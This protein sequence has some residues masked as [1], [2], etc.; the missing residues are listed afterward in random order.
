MNSLPPR[1]AFFSPNNTVPNYGI[2][3]RMEIASQFSGAGGLDLGFTRAGHRVVWEES[4]MLHG[5]R[6]KES[7]ERN[8]KCSM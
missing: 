3:L 1:G 7:Q 2:I 6:A 8:K 5:E 4:G